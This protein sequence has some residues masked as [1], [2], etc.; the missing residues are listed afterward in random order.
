ME[1]DLQ[2]GAL[3]RPAYGQPSRSV[4]AGCANPWRQLVASALIAV[5]MMTAGIVTLNELMH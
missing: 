1:S 4:N 5:V 3:V 2:P